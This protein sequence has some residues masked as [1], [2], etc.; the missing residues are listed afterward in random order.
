MQ[1]TIVLK[2][3]GEPVAKGRPRVTRHGAYTPEKTINYETLVKQLYITNKLPKLD[4]QLR[5]EINAYF[6]IPKSATKGKRLAMEH[7]ITRPTKRPDGDN[8]LKII[9]D[10]LNGL[11]YDDD[12]QVVDSIVR[13][14]Y[15]T[16]PRVEVE[17]SEVVV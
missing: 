16:E 17:I 1:N 13:K 4:G 3:P 12:S 7:N 2:I 9:G 10:A 11:A 8:I 6:K 14:W 15:S 5:M